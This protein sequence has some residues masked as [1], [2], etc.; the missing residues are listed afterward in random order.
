[1]AF[2]MNIATARPSSRSARLW[3]RWSSSNHD[4]LWRQR[5]FVLLMLLFLAGILGLVGMLY[6]AHRNARGLYEQMA[7]QGADVQMRMIRELRSLYSSEVVDRV[8]PYGIQATHDY[9][10]QEREIPL[11]AT[12]TM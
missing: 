4:P 6:Q 12:L 7:L 5:S 9:R 2:L 8:L 3:G 11:P 1:M 10:Q